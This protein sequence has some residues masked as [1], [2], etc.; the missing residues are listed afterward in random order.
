MSYLI[1]LWL[2]DFHLRPLTQDTLETRFLHVLEVELSAGG[3]AVRHRALL[4][5]AHHR[6]TEVVLELQGLEV[7]FYGLL[8]FLGL[9]EVPFLHV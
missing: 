8:G 2:R 7:V 3:R 1:L 9:E 6:V 4:N 5:E